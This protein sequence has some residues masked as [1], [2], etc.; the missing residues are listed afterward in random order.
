MDV[1]ISL[2]YLPH[3]G[4]SATTDDDYEIDSI[5]LVHGFAG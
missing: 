4:G 5:P 2:S 1:Q 3:C